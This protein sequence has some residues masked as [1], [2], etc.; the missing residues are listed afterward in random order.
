MDTIRE[1]ASFV[2]YMAVVFAMLAVGCDS[3]GNV[4]SEQAARINSLTTS[5][6]E[7]ADDRTREKAIEELATQGDVASDGLRLVFQKVDNPQTRAQAAKAMA[8]AD[9]M[10]AVPDLINAL[11]DENVE[12][13]RASDDALRSLLSGVSVRYDA[14][15]SPEER[16]AAMERYRGYWN[17]RNTD[18]LNAIGK[19]KQKAQ[20]AMQ[21][22]T[23]FE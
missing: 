19:D 2:G 4:E 7:A 6:V 10:E 16:R 22:Q 14:N 12:L 9:A 13:R 15:A 3:T 21:Q 20:K 8:D 18:E 23:I 1:S 5:A 11:D 17:R